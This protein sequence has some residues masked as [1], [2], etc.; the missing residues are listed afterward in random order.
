MTKH[1]LADAE[2]HALALA[3][4]AKAFFDAAIEEAPDELR[5][6]LGKCT[7]IAVSVLL[8]PMPHVLISGTGMGQRVQWDIAL[9]PKRTAVN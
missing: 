4:D 9:E 3:R 8:F 2:P 6:R 7:Q 5:Q 1:R